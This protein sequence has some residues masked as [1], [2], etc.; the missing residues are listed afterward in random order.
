M[1]SKNLRAFEEFQRR[2]GNPTSD[3]ALRALMGAVDPE[4]EFVQ[5]PSLPHGGVHRGYAG[6][7]EMREMIADRWKVAVRHDHMWDVPEDDAIF[8]YITQEWTSTE[9]GKTVKFPTLQWISFKDAKMTRL[10][11]FVQDT[12]K[13]IDT[14]D[15]D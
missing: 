8:L 2:L 5:A 10:E 1:P 12:K 15:A 7:R 11:I 14:L 4:V 3:E 13:I 9:T 6:A